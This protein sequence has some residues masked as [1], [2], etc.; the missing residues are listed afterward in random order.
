[1]AASQ[2]PVLIAGA[3]I[4][5]LTLALA[6]AR[7]GIE[8][9]VLEQ[10]DTLSEIGAGVQLTPNAARVLI[11]LGL[12]SALQKTAASPEFITI[13]SGETGR[14]LTRMMLGHAIGK[15]YGAPWWVIHRA[16]LQAALA[17]AVEADPLTALRRGARVETVSAGDADATVTLAGGETVSGRALVGA[18][19]V[20]STVR[21]SIFPDSR[22][23]F[24]GFVAFRGTTDAAHAPDTDMLTAGHLWLAPEAHLVHYP[25][26]AGS[27]IN[28]V[29]IISGER[30][31]EGWAEKAD[32][33]ELAPHFAGWAGNARKLLGAVPS[34]TRWPLYDLAP[35]PRWSAGPVTLLGDAAHAALPFQAQ[36][37]AMAIEDAA[38]LAACMADAP[39]ETAF[40]RYEGLRQARTARIQAS[41]RRNGRIFHLGG[42]A[43]LARDAALKLASRTLAARQHWIYSWRLDK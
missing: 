34:W 3:G 40:A 18:D 9:L 26:R 29:A 1:M 27:R 12:E 20:R 14:E 37:A 28:V 11:G 5:G 21:A 7:K 23:V 24:S 15:R 31:T 25:V 42:P 33:D 8:S 30:V 38:V 10:A 13:R 36:G 2:K 6:L 4:G 41:S 22:P 17:A 16:D 32:P 43:R 39:P 35:M 19:G